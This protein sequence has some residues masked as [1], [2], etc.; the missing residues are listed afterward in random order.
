MVD[1]F[2]G[3]WQMTESEKFDEFMSA[4]GISW[5]V[6][7]LA[8]STKPVVT[9]S[10]NGDEITIK[11]VS[12]VKTSE[13]KFKLGEEFEEQRADGVKVKSV[14]KFEDNK[15]IQVILTILN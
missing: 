6:R 5:V 8:Q 14:I 3:S 15:L 9:F 11:T 10:Q 4:L 12:A 1:Q 2:L 13:I 7:R